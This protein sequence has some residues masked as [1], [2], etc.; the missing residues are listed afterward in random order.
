[1]SNQNQVFRE[2]LEEGVKWED[3]MKVMNTA[4]ATLMFYDQVH[5][6][7]EFG[8]YHTNVNLTVKSG[9]GNDFKFIKTIKKEEVFT[10]EQI[11]AN[12]NALSNRA[13]KGWKW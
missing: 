5:V 3:A 8:Q 1:M 12:L 10:E 2:I 4:L 6:Y 9:Y 7:H 13:G 11:K